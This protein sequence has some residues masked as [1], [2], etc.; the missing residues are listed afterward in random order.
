MRGG[1]IKHFGGWVPEISKGQRPAFFSTPSIGTSN[2]VRASIRNH[3][4]TNILHTAVPLSTSQL[5][6]PEVSMRTHMPSCCSWTAKILLQRCGSAIRGSGRRQDCDMKPIQ[7]NRILSFL[8]LDRWDF[9]RGST[10]CSRISQRFSHPSHVLDSSQ[11]FL[12]RSDEVS[13]SWAPTVGL[14][15][16][17]LCIF[18]IA[19]DCSGIYKILL[20]SLVR[21]KHLQPL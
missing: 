10:D 13:R 8:G 3:P 16:Y 18:A 15:I 11:V 2:R 6:R 5:C 21:P 12:P 7:W 4:F 20:Q 9:D 19:S 17:H 14:P 1:Q